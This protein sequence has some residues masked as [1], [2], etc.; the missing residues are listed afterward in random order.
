MSYYQ[1]CNA[2]ALELARANI[3]PGSRAIIIPY[4]PKFQQP[5]E[6]RAACRFCRKGYDTIRALKSHMGSVHERKQNGAYRP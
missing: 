5:N 2:Q 3:F 1:G 6:A 4:A